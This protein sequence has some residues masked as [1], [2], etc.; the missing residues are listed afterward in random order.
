MSALP[1]PKDRSFGL[2]VAWQMQS[3]LL[4]FSQ[5]MAAE[6]GDLAFFR[7]GPLKICLLN[8]PDLI[9]EALSTRVKWF[10]KYQRP[11]R[12][13]A[14]MDGQAITVTEGDAWLRGRRVVQPAFHQ[15]HF[16][17]YGE[18]VV[19]AT[20][21]MIDGWEP[22]AIVDVE[23]AFRRLTLQTMTQTLLGDDAASQAK[24]IE[25]ASREFLAIITREL[26]RPFDLPDWLPLPSKFRKRRAVRQVRGFVERVIDARRAV[27]RTRGDLLSILMQAA[28]DAAGADERRRRL[29]NQQALDEAIGLFRAGHDAMSSL[30]TWTTALLAQHPAIAVKVREEVQSVTGGSPVESKDWPQL[31]YTEC[32]AK[33]SLRL[34]PPAWMLFVRQAAEDVELTCGESGPYRIPRGT[35]VFVT[36]WSV[37]RDPRFFSNPRS[38]D[39][40]RFLPDRIA[41]IRPH[42]FIP[43]G[44]GPHACIGNAYSLMHATLSVAVL[45][46]RGRWNVTPPHDL[47]PE[48]VLP[49]RI[50]GGLRI[51]I[52]CE[53]STDSFARSRPITAGDST[54]PLVPKSAFGSRISL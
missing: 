16:A 33:E 25:D 6:F 8:H 40:D 37:H 53:R 18:I 14:K 47:A 31:A 28:V 9:H 36:P 43:F 26:Y 49:L 13:L 34:Y 1:G 4:R 5:E 20:N 45:A 22:N 27:G 41:A 10:P 15:S 39:P 48:P 51:L 2:G 19:K 12:Q 11:I 42:A 7:V 17:A 30:L 38:V 54:L 44:I 23:E 3:N 50:R 35:Q 21:A 46:Q 24:L 52:A 29:S 32:V